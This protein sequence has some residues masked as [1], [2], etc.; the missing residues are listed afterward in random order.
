M[1]SEVGVASRE[2]LVVVDKV[3]M[4]YRVPTNESRAAGSS[5]LLASLRRTVG[6]G[7]TVEVQALK[8]VSLVVGR[9]ESVGIIGR[10]GSGKSTLMKLVNGRVPPTSGAVYS[11]SHPTLLGVSAALIPDISGQ[12]NIVLGCLA[13]GMSKQDIGRK[14]EDIVELSG[15][16]ESI[17][18]PMRTYS[19]GMGSRLQFAIA[20]AVDPEVLLIDEALNTGDDQFKGRTKR[21]MNELRERAGCVFL[22]SHS[23]GTI[24]QLCTRVIWLDE[25]EV[26][27]DGDP[28]Y[29]TRWYRNYVE[30]LTAG[31][32]SEGRK[33]KAR[34]MRNRTM[35][36]IV[37]QEPG[38]RRR[39]R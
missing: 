36:R 29:V 34:L 10:N 37:G 14:Y 30:Q 39:A 2:P 3:S 38:R 16:G 21:R 1:T 11:S 23:L 31:D 9:G 28:A 7:P 18:R 27:T 6:S 5:G 8:D 24:R 33:I 12:Q 13:M 26:V 15:L 20:T 4:T 19:S 25:G 35:P 22:V 17:H 32:L